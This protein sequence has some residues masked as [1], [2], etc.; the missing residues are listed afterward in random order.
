M[1]LSAGRP[2]PRVILCL[3]ATLLAPAA[4]GAENWPRAKSPAPASALEARARSDRCRYD[5]RAKGRANDPGRH[6]LDQAPMTFDVTTLALS[7]TAAAPGQ[8]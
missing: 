1:K 8:P 6:S 7:S 5:A 4:M 2:R 3:A